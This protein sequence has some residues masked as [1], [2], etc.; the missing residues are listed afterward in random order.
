[1]LVNAAFSLRLLLTVM[2][3]V[4]VLRAAYFLLVLVLEGYSL[5]SW[6]VIDSEAI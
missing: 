5:V 1:M 2:H 3:V 4:I 6:L